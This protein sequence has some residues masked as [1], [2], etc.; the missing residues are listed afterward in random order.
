MQLIPAQKLAEILKVN[1]TTIER[2]AARGIYKYEYTEG[3]GRGGYQMLIALES[4]PE[5]ERDRYHGI[6]K[7]RR[8][9]ELAQFT[10]DQLHAANEKKGCVL[11]YWRS[12][13]SPPSS[14]PSATPWA[15][16]RR[17]RRASCMHGS[18]S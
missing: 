2:R 13:L 1:V 4:L 9:E 16:M 10:H 8:E 11:E 12:G 7:E 14:W 5:N 3:R 15:T 6:E 17:S 18:V